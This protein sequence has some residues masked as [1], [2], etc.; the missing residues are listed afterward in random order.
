M[1]EDEDTS[2]EP[3]KK[4]PRISDLPSVPPSPPEKVI[5][6]IFQYLDTPDLSTC[7]YVCKT[8]NK[9]SVAT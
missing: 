3:P 8:W 7:R 1:L 4:V 6:Y 2:L 9:L 5:L